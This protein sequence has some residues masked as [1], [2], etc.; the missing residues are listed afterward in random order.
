M[1]RRAHRNRKQSEQPVREK[2]ALPPLLEMPP[3]ILP[4]YA[5]LELYG[6]RE[7]VIDG[8]KGILEYSEELIR[9]NLGKNLTKITGRSLQIKCMTAS[10]VV[11]E[12]Y[13]LSLEF[14]E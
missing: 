7:L 4:D 3:S 1:N 2:G 8:C 11:I 12:G 6:N 9:L 14:I 10:S 5:Q 13:I